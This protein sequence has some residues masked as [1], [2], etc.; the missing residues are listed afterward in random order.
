MEYDHI[1]GVKA[2][3]VSTIICRV[4]IDWAKECSVVWTKQTHCHSMN[5]GRVSKSVT[6][7]QP[8]SINNCDLVDAKAI[9]F[10]WYDKEQRLAKLTFAV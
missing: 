7:S 4:C 5:G 1:Q 9:I 10:A 3:D 8:N 6:G 2:I